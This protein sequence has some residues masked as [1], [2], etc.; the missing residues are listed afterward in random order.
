M[1]TEQATR[2]AIEFFWPRL[3]PGGKIVVDD[4]GWEPCAG[5][6]KAVE[7]F[8]AGESDAG[9]IQPTQM[10]AV[11]NLYTVVLEK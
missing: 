4:Y 11:K 5:V 7:D 2:D 8:Y 3:V 1:D 9:R 10:R 6:K